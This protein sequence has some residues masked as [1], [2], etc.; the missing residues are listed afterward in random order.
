M[1]LDYMVAQYEKNK[2]ILQILYFKFFVRFVQMMQT[3]PDVVW[4]VRHIQS[5]Y[6]NFFYQIWWSL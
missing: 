5:T 1:V 4:L 6:F 2:H 3:S